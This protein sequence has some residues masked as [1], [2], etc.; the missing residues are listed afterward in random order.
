MIEKGRRTEGGDW[1]FGGAAVVKLGSLKDG[2]RDGRLLVISKD[3]SRAVAAKSVAVTMLGAVETWS[4]S[5][6]KLA[7]LYERLNA[8]EV[9]GT[10]ELDVRKLS[11]PLPRAPQWLDASAFHSHGNLMDKVFG[12]QPIEG[13]LTTPLMYQGAS[14]DFLGP[15]DDMPMPSE[16][17]GIDFEAEV[18]VVVDQVTMGTPAAKALDRVKLL[19]LINDASLRIL[20][21]REI[22]T[23]FGF[24]QSKPSTSF[25]PVAVTPDELGVAWHDSRVH[26]AVSVHFNGRVFGT[27]NAG[28]MGFGFHDLIAHAAR[29][30]TLHA[31]TIIGSG[32]ISNEEYRTCGSAC[33]A[34]RRGIET[35]DHGKAATPYM[36]FGDEVRIEMLDASGH[37]V[38]GAIDQRMVEAPRP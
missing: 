11:A 2:S 25:A 24:L 22:K 9:P 5:A 18:G 36:K 23:G 33:I 13:K 30:R 32:T 34:E 21:G 4:T 19:V 7:A 37:S 16:A 10:F 20:A 17:D 15:R 28:R 8:G 29:T 3:L 14:D 12:M 26:L 27:P 35:V 31:G 6:A 38:F 1:S